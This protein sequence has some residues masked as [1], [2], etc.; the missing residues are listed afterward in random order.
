MSDED[1]NYETLWL[2]S[3]QTIQYACMTRAARTVLAEMTKCH[4]RS[5]QM[6]LCW[7]HQMI[8]S[9]Q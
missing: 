4:C 2:T 9:L 5:I 1:V 7:V 8:R 3:I 6:G